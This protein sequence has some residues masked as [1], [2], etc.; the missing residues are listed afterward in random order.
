LRSGA[1]GRNDELPG[2][3]SVVHRGVRLGDLIEA[4]DTVNRY[5]DVAG[6][7]GVEEFL[8]NGLG[9]V[10]GLAAVGRQAYS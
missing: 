2:C 8:Q 9:Q 3:A 7:D 6:G 5:D 10:L 1:S 4:V